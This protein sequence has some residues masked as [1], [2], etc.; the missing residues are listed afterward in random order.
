MSE[1]IEINTEKLK[2]L[3]HPRPATTWWCSPTAPTPSKAVNPPPT[4]F[5]SGDGLADLQKKNYVYSA[6]VQLCRTLKG[7]LLS[8]NGTGLCPTHLGPFSSTFT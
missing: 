4:Y 7:K 5:H 2:K 6:R 1:K 3:F 8:T